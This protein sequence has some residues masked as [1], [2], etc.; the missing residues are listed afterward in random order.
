MSQNSTFTGNVRTMNKIENR[1][2]DI[3]VL[4]CQLG[5]KEG[6]RGEQTYISRQNTTCLIIIHITF[7]YIFD[8]CKENK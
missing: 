8:N 5:L 4:K 7:N 3:P 1:L 6:S 2:M